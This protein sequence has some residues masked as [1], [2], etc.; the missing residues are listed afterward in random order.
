MF[1]TEV[2]TYASLPCE[3]HGLSQSECEKDQSCAFNFRRAANK[4]RIKIRHIYFNG[5]GR[6]VNIT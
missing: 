2:T 3:Q 4:W 1:S 6:N 5:E